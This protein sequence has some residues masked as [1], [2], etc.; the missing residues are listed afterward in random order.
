MKV[1]GTASFSPRS[2]GTL[3]RHNHLITTMLVKICDNVK[4]SKNNALAWAI[5]AKNSLINHN[6]FSTSQIVFRKNSNL[7]NIINETLPALE[8]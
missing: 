1:L 4:C 5:S 7:P 2:N 8:K 3:E 6:G